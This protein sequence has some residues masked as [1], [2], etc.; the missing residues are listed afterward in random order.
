LILKDEG[1]VAIVGFFVEQKPGTLFKGRQRS[2]VEERLRES[3]LE[4]YDKS[5]MPNGNNTQV[6]ML[7]MEM[8]LTGIQEVVSVL[9]VRA[10]KCV[11]AW[12]RM[13]H[14]ACF[15]IQWLSGCLFF[16]CSCPYLRT[17]DINVCMSA[18]G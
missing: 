1:A 9:K 17:S 7:K 3:L 4:K 13:T 18:P 8:I 10:S 15:V 12:F 2:L 6:F 14:Q 16:N 11:T 5:I